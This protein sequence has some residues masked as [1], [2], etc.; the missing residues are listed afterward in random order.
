M[1]TQ[2]QAFS[3]RRHGV[4]RGG[5]AVRRRASG[6][7]DGGR[8]DGGG[9][10][11]HF[12]TAVGKTEASPRMEKG[13]TC[14]MK[15]ACHDNGLPCAQHQRRAP[16]HTGQPRRPTGQKLTHGF[17]LTTHRAHTVSYFFA[18]NVSCRKTTAAA[19]PPS[20]RTHAPHR[21][22]R[23]PPW[24]LPAPHCAPR[25]SPGGEERGAQR[26][27]LSDIRGRCVRCAA[28]LLRRCRIR[29]RSRGCRLLRWLRLAR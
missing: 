8:T 10:L 16:H 29:A 25:A 12:W 2:Q 9:A 28:G 17:M 21:S 20:S 26:D 24:P 4:G 1:T 15:R 3:R 22:T 13:W 27:A 23:T 7:R 5:T 11:P 14:A 6:L 18:P 19:A